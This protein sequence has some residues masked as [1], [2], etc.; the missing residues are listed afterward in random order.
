ME[1]DADIETPDR[2]LEVVGDQVEKERA[3]GLVGEQQLVGFE[4]QCSPLVISEAARFVSILFDFCLLRDSR[5]LVSIEK[6]S[7]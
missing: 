4:Q 3:V 2:V 5:H 6:V 7:G 1:L